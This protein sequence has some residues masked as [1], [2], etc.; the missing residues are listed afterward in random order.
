MMF[1]ETSGELAY[2]LP[3]FPE[4]RTGAHSSSKLL[5]LR[6]KTKTYSLIIFS[7]WTIMQMKFSLGVCFVLLNVT[8]GEVAF[9]GTC[10]SVPHDCVI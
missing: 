8:D 2:T 3:P 6:Q 9:Q 10:L 7:I 1:Y 4:T 5:N